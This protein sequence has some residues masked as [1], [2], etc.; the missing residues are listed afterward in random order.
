ML[1]TPAQRV[2]DIR[3]QTFSI[4][5]EYPVFFTRNAFAPTNT[6]LLE[7]LKR[8]ESDKRHR[9]CRAR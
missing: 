3:F 9:F 2:E 4:N 6:C 1:D 8:R 5:C 7:A